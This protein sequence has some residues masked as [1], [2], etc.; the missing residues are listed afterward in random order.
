MY[1]RRPRKG[2]YARRRPPALTSTRRSARRSAW[3]SGLGS[4]RRRGA[5]RWSRR[6]RVTRRTRLRRASAPLPP[7]R[8]ILDRDLA[9]TARERLQDAAARAGIRA[10]RLAGQRIVS[11]RA[12]SSI[13]S[14]AE[15]I[16]FAREPPTL[17]KSSNRSCPFGDQ[18]RVLRDDVLRLRE[19]LVEHRYSM[20]SCRR[21]A[22][23]RRGLPRRR[24][25][26][27]TPAR[28]A[29]LRT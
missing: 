22:R 3:G 19:D 10:R 28:I 25:S 11:R 14:S 1:S 15:R 27:T 20:R 7:V 23:P 29:S 9:A 12:Y 26:T 6:S 13:A 8:A 4:C 24:T 18:H 17:M 21:R 5:R 16:R 2:P